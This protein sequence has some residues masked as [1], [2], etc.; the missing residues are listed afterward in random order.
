MF[1]L[2]TFE[3]FITKKKFSLKQHYENFGTF[4]IAH[5]YKKLGNSKI[6]IQFFT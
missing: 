1:V 5:G 3:V 4:S 2:E 6:Y